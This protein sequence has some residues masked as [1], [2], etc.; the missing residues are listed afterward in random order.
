M[1]KV[2]GT[3][4]ICYKNGRCCHTFF[5]KSSLK[6][7]KETLNENNLY[8]FRKSIERLK[9]VNSVPFEMDF[10][11]MVYKEQAFSSVFSLRSCKLEKTKNAKMKNVHF[12]VPLS[13]IRHHSVT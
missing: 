2:T 13:S 5:W 10:E 3:L 8:S 6:L 4:K 7:E 1:C 12:Q 11:N 9:Y